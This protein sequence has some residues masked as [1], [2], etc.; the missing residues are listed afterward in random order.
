MDAVPNRK[1]ARRYP[2]LAHDVERVVGRRID[3]V[4][5]RLDVQEPVVLLHSVRRKR[6][7]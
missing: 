6:L 2:A 7:R 3:D 4:L 1:V 5:A